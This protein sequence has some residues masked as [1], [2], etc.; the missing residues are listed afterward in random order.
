MTVAHGYGAGTYGAGTY[1]GVTV[2]ADPRWL[3]MIPD[4]AGNLYD[5]GCDVRSVSIHAGRSNYV[6]AFSAATAAVELQN[7]TGKYSAWPAD[8]VWLQP[9]GWVTGVPISIGVAWK[10]AVAWRFVGTTDAV[11]DSWPGMADA[12][13]MV[14]A[15][16]GFKGLSRNAG[17]ARAAVGAGELSGARINRLATDAAWS[18]PRAVDVGIVALQGTDLA[19]VTLDAM[20]R[21]GEAEWG[22]LFIAADGTLT[23]RQRDAAANDP[24]MVNVQYTFTDTHGVAGA[25]YGDATVVGADDATIVN[26]ATVTPPGHPA[27]SY[28]DAASVA[29]YGPRTW[30]RTD[31]LI[32][33]DVDAVALAQAVVTSFKSDA[34]RIDAIAID[35]ANHAD[36]WPAA[37]GARINDR[38][39]FVRTMPGGYQLDAELL[40]QGRV[41]TME[42]S[43]VDGALAVWSVEFQTASA[44]SV[45]DLGRWDQPAGAAVGWDLSKWGI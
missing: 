24:R 32:N 5:V 35:A 31:L 40:V 33:A 37:T 36:A 7:F 14:T 23:F 25:C 42:P 22:W 2:T 16:D 39:R 8:S 12:R 41:D 43:G 17:A 11:S 13:V 6:A 45:A 29:H 44:S 38:V 34:E 15:T 19:G 4:A 20:R 26:V 18:G 27:S 1:G 21:V 28:T 9:G 30:S 3:V 10:G